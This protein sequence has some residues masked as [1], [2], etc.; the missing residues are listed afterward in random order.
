MKNTKQILLVNAVVRNFRS[1]DFSIP[2]KKQ[3]ESLGRNAWVK[4]SDDLDRF[5]V[6]VETI[7]TNKGN[8]FYEGRID[9]HLISGQTDYGFGDLIYFTPEN[10]IDI[11][12]KTN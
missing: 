10:I 12:I 1:K 9:N 2:S 11:L 6:K 3:R 4:V 5:W 7:T 8:V